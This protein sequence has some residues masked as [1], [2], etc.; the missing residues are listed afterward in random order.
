MLHF[1]GKAIQG[2]KGEIFYQIPPKARDQQLEGIIKRG[3]ML[4]WNE[5]NRQ[6]LYTQSHL[7]RTIVA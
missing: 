4:N 5:N 3:L 1:K 7:G 6:N 2:F